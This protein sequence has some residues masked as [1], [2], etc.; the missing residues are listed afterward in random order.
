MAIDLQY[1][2]DT[3]LQGLNTH[4]VPLEFSNALTTGEW[5][6][7]IQALIDGISTQNEDVAK[8]AFAKYQ[9]QFDSL[10][11][12]VESKVSDKSILDNF[13]TYINN[14]T[15]ASIEKLVGDSIK[16]VTFGLTD[17]GYFYANI[18][19]SWSN[20]SFDTNVDSLSSDYGKLMITY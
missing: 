4:P 6:C 15:T 8:E 18:P 2:K 13:K 14:Y 3:F 12:Q 7:A 10:I 20:L 16:F 1:Y 9:V 17:D 5:L 11:K 19:S